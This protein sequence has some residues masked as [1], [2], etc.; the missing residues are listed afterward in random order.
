MKLIFSILYAGLPNVLQ[1]SSASLVHH[2]NRRTMFI[3]CVIVLMSA[4][5]AIGLKLCPMATNE[6]CNVTAN[7]DNRKA[8][9]DYQVNVYLSATIHH[10][11]I[12]INTI[13]SDKAINIDMKSVNNLTS[14]STSHYN[15]VWTK[16]FPNRFEF[17]RSLINESAA[18]AQNNGT[19]EGELPQ[20]EGGGG[21]DRE[22][23][24]CSHPEYI[25]FTWVR[26]N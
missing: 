23:D 10:N 19:F 12:T 11:N 25:V 7:L 18:A 6:N 13:D 8:E 22:T 16:V 5:S 20:T 17:L 14:S 24:P 3:C 9:L 15:G 2:R 1:R 26:L 4:V 21:T